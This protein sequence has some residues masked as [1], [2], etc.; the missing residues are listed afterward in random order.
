M[1]GPLEVVVLVQ[2]HGPRAAITRIPVDF[3]CCQVTSEDAE[4]RDIW[5]HKA[6]L[7]G[8]GHGARTW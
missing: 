3:P 2:A 4:R 5:R 8:N 7:D 1:T 6:G